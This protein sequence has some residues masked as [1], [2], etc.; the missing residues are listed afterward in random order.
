[1]KAISQFPGCVLFA[2]AVVA[3]TTNAASEPM[4]KDLQVSYDSPIVIQQGAATITLADFIAFFEWRV[5]EDQRRRVLASPARIEG[6]LESAVLSSGF[7]EKVER[8]DNWKDPVV[9]ARLYQAAAREARAIYADQLRSEESL[10][11]YETQARELFMLN[12]ER[13]TSPQTIDFEHILIMD[14]GTR[15]EVA[16]M[17]EALQAYEAL[18]ETPF[19]QVAAEYSDEAA[20]EEHGG[21]FA[22]V[23]LDDLVTPMAEAAR[24]AELNQFSAPIRSQFGWHIF[25]VT[26]INE[27][28]PLTWEQ[29]QPLAEEMARERHM[30]EI[31]E[32]RLRELSSAP[33]QFAEGAVK[34]IL[35]HYGISG[36]EMSPPADDDDG[37]SQ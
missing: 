22:N 1:M 29:A 31:F 10:D 11:S 2:L 15:G 26:A 3:T 14:D 36:F 16:L 30:S 17:T 27:P 23:S 24:G 20:F 5:P 4:T 21:K 25:R 13:F 34:S 33:M 19:D 35:D 28:E 8:S 32:R 7:L 37:S 6:L 12:P 18:A 9:Q